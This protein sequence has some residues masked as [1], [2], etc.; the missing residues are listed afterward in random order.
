MKEMITISA[1]IVLYNEDIDLLRKTVDSFLQIDEHFQLFL[2]D[3]SPNPTQPSFDNTNIEYIANHSN[4]GFGAGHNKVI[5]KIKNKSKY[6]LVLNP[7]VQFEPQ[8]IS[9]LI[10]K[11]ETENEVSMIA[12][13]I[14]FPNKEFQISCR[15]Y[16]TFL[17]LLSRRF[18]V[19]KKYT[20]KFEYQKSALQKPLYPDYI[21][22]C[23]MLFKTQDFVDLNGFDERYF[24][25]MEDVDICKKIDAIGMHKIYYPHVQI[26]HALR[27]GSSKNFQM[28]ARHLTSA[29]KYFN[30]WGF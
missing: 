23:F 22:G 27:K 11:L 7:D 8:V 12:P 24:L 20:Q 17:A 2:I 15:K 18:G 9:E 5:D 29:M 14:I 10:K 19:L 30:K 26:I 13:R 4:V 3:N 28:F 16:P 21:H 1:S 6:H 25:Y